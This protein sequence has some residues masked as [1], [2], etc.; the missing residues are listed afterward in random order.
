M[1]QFY[2]DIPKVKWV[3]FNESAHCA[4]VEQRAKYMQVVS[5]FLRA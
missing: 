4:H 5:V 3:T 1:Y 2:R